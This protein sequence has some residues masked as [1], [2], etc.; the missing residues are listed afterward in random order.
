ML[1]TIKN[2]IHTQPPKGLNK[3][4]NNTNDPSYTV[5]GANAEKAKHDMN[6]IGEMIP[7]TYS[8]ITRFQP[9]SPHDRGVMDAF[10]ASMD[11]NA[12]FVNSTNA[13]ACMLIGCS[14][15]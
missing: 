6:G 10:E 7:S 3:Q 2:T 5:P 12:D 13:K 1:A 9:E 11:A 8:L 14:S 15:R 4:F